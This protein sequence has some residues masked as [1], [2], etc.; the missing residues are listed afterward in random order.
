MS[1]PRSNILDD[2]NRQLNLREITQSVAGIITIKVPFNLTEGAHIVK[3]DIEHAGDPDGK[4]SIS[5]VI[6]IG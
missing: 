2:V 3:T 1:E 6:K 4:C 5:L